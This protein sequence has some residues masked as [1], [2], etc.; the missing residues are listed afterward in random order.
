M[1]N[2][3]GRTFVQPPLLLA[4]SRDIMGSGNIEKGVEMSCETRKFE[5][6]L[7]GSK[8]NIIGKEFDREGYRAQKAG[9]EAH[10]TNQNLANQIRQAS[11]M[12][13]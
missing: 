3:G 11:G 10:L 4:F 5:K 12:S 6:G 13:H 9:Y 7:S 8:P 1:Q 2:D